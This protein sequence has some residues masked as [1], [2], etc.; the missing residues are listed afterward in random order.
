M[1]VSSLRDSVIITP[2]TEVGAPDVYGNPTMVDGAPVTAKAI[3]TPSSTN[4][5]E[6]GRDTRIQSYE[7]IVA[8][9]VSINA[10]SK[11]TWRGR[12]FEV[13]GEPSLFTS[14]GLPHHYQFEGVEE[15]G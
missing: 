4:E 2:R 10:L 5:I 6:D 14:R 13:Q 9:T 1:I 8:A 7:F 15:L 11:V 12:T 3:V